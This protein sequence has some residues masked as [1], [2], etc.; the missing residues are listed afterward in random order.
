M[1]I[2]KIGYGAGTMDCPQF[3]N[4]VRLLIG[5][6]MGSPSATTDSVCLLETNIDDV[7]GEVVASAMDKLLIAG[8]LDVFT[9][10]ITMKQ[11]RPATKLSV[12]CEPKDIGKL[13]QIIFESGLTFGI[14]RQTLQRNKLAREFITVSTR[15]GDIK[16]KIGSYAG[17]VVNAKPEF[18]DCARAA[19]KY[20]TSVKEVIEAA[21]QG[22]G[23][24][25]I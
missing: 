12:I 10:A 13:E 9:S 4:V 17:R 16:I 8:A 14:R 20:N 3:P 21:M 11:N 22:Y 7:S 5:E 1:K 6:V 25:K 19:Q 23:Q 18:A 24:S 15:F 2:E